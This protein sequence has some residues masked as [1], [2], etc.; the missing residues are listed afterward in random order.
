MQDSSRKSAH[1][2]H[3]ATT[4][5]IV[6]SFALVYFFWGST[7][8]AISI[9]VADLPPLL[10]GGVRFLASG[11]LLLLYC[12]R[13]GLKLIWPWR[14]MLVMGIVGVLLLGGGNVG[15][16]YAEETVPSGFSS[17]VIAVVPLYVALMEMLLPGGEPLPKRGWLGMAMGLVSLI[18]LLWPSIH[19]GLEGNSKMLLALAAL[20]G[21]ALSWAAGSV[22]ARRRRLAANSFVQASWQMLIAGA[23][24]LLCGTLLGEWPAFHM[25]HRAAGA[26]AWLVTGGSLI[27]Y[28]AYIYLLEHVPVTKVASYAYV[29][30]VVA[31]LL[32][33]LVLS[34][35]PDLIEF[36]G[37]VGII[38]AV[39][40]L[41]TAQVR[42]KAPSMEDMQQLPAE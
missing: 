13:R 21:C 34:E 19:T 10:M 41:T 5:T 27:G 42:K 31:V 16:I 22:Y 12:W 4:T 25:T 7:Y 32:G 24:N 1:H 38:A 11:A 29:N 6:I 40:L 17:L 3:A 8:T 14:M 39:Y 33:I 26:I 15:L 9:G 37:M 18:V 23:V 28:S 20:L 36:I 35:Q 2:H 30:P